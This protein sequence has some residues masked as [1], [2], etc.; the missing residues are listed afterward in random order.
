MGI[1]GPP[2]GALDGLSEAR[3]VKRSHSGSSKAR[4]KSG[5]SLPFSNVLLNV[6]QVPRTEGC[7]SHHG[8]QGRFGGCRRL[9][10][11]ACGGRGLPFPPRALPRPPPSRGLGRGRSS[12]PTSPRPARPVRPAPAPPSG[13]FRGRTRAGLGPRSLRT[14]LGAPAAPWR[15]GL[16]G[17]RAALREEEPGGVRPASPGRRPPSPLGISGRPDGRGVGA[18]EPAP[19][20][21]SSRA[22]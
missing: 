3:Q 1:P 22:L 10:R 11:A 18:G 14:A 12:P 4:G 20:F 2:R 19:H 6:G 16:R 21:D 8:L 15:T 7:L 9:R 5:Q 17:R 13:K